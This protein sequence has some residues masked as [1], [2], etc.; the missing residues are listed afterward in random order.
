MKEHI[1]SLFLDLVVDS[2]AH[3]YYLDNILQR[4]VTTTIKNIY[5]KPF[6]YEIAVHSGRKIGLTENEELARWK[7]AGDIAC[8]KGHIEHDKKEQEIITGDLSIELYQLLSKYNCVAVTTELP[9]YSRKYKFAGTFDLLVYNLD[10]NEYEIW[11]YKTNIDIYKNFKYQMMLPPFEDLLDMPLNHY[12]IQLAMYALCLHEKDI[13]NL[14]IGRILWL[15]TGEVISYPF[16]EV[17]D[18]I[19][20]TL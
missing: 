12:K 11:D 7:L 18:K 17:L 6:P 5:V 1:E 16:D 19:K 15:T 20:L 4:G 9:V 10:T 8:A 13:K 3:K 14:K 2:E